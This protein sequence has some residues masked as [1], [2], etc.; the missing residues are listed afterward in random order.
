MEKFDLS[1]L[2]K[3]Q[4]V[5]EIVLDFP[6]DETERVFFN[7]YQTWSPSHEEKPSIAVRTIHP[8]IKALGRP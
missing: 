7:G 5:S 3:R 1:P 4:S 2:I 8:V 6:C